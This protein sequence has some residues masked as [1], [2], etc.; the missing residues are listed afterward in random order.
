MTR[1][2]V[3]N[4]FR[5]VASEEFACIPDEENIIYEFSEGFNRKMAKLIKKTENNTKH[6]SPKHFMMSV[7]TIAASFAIVLTAVMLLSKQ[8][9]YPVIDPATTNFPSHNETE[10]IFINKVQ[11][12]KFGFI[13]CYTNPQKEEN[14]KNKENLYGI[15]DS[16]G[17][18]IVEPK[19]ANAFPV[20]RKTFAISKVVEGETYSSMI[21]YDGKIIVSSF[22]G[23]IVAVC[24][25]DNAT[26][27][28]IAPKDEKS[29]L[30][31]MTGKKLLDCDFNSV[32]VAS[33]TN[34]NIL[35]AYTDESAYYISL[36]GKIIAEFPASKP[37]IDPFGEGNGGTV[38]ACCYL[39][40]EAENRIFYG[41]YDSKSGREIVPCTR[42]NGFAINEERYV[43]K[44]TSAMGPDYNDFAAIY[45][46]DGNVIC[47]DGEY[48]DI[49]FRYGS[50]FGIGV[51][52]KP[53]EDL[54][55]S[56]VKYYL[57]DA[58]GN[59]LSEALDSMPDLDK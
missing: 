1:T 37:V 31:D 28:I 58:D 17:N 41:L 6:G 59:A 19:Y 48:H 34:Q 4:A 51:T 50:S 23:E 32:Y 53:T 54:M 25:E 33:E 26:I 46:K 11:P 16:E 29:Y 43:L 35:E 10:G 5:E 40:E 36:D 9:N 24:H 55:G 52:I 21:D 14:L 2:E 47:G 39:P 15:M 3:L 38:I 27:A 56:E 57:I 42:K 12:L 22:K 44:D 20:S 7:L 13:S 8:P 30:V 49:I 45:D 18:I